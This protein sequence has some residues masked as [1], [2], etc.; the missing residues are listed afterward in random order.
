M[1]VCHISICM[2]LYEKGAFVSLHFFQLKEEAE[3]KDDEA[4]GNQSQQSG[5]VVETK[6]EDVSLS[7]ICLSCRHYTFHDELASV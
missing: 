7:V 4:K 1:A 6:D 3:K 5:D 2:P